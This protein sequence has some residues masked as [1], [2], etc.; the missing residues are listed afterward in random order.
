MVRESR[1]Q[2]SLA[3]QSDRAR[4]ARRR[5][6]TIR[7]ARQ[8]P[9]ARSGATT[10]LVFSRI[11]TNGPPTPSCEP[12]LF[13]I[14]HLARLHHRETRNPLIPRDFR[15][16]VQKRDQA[17]EVR[18]AWRCENT[19]RG[20]SLPGQW[21]SGDQ[22]GLDR[23]SP[24]FSPVRKPKYQ[25]ILYSISRARSADTGRAFKDAPM[26]DVHLSNYG[27]PASGAWPAA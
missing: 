18:A 24:T 23:A 11:V 19:M 22:D 21:G 13:I 12:S 3:G 7:D 26:C 27:G 25:L 10:D 2:R 5:Q 6:L 8:G 1:L 20:P 9:V 4:L 17:G 14:R 15:V 16:Y